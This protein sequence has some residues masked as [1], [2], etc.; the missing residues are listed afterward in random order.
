MD[1]FITLLAGLCAGIACGTGFFLIM[2]TLTSIEIA[3]NKENDL[4]KKR[5]PVLIR[6]FLPLT[7]N[8]AKINRMD[9]LSDYRKTISEKL[10][11]S[12]YDSVLTAE[13]FIAVRICLTV[14]GVLMVVL[15]AMAGKPL[16]GLIF[17]AMMYIYPGA[18]IRSAVTKR[19]YE[20]MRALPNMLD[21]LTLS[22]EAGKDFL[23]ALRDILL[24][25]KTDALGEEFMRALQEIQLGKKRQSALREMAGRIQLPELTSI[26]NAI[27]QADE[28]GI[29]IGQLLRIQ[30]DQLRAKRFSYAEKLANEAP[31]KILVPVVMFIFPS[32]FLLLMGPIL[33]QAGKMLG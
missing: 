30:S 32:V 10:M 19:H 16:Y 1:Q 15:L 25:R 28:L 6:L 22:V 13:Q 2:K 26:V 7:P 33:L 12:G 29:S 17:T 14:F 23:S 31:V 9:S 5:L 4:P 21:L 20:I 11:M 24:K 27:V 18:W 8:L 3:E